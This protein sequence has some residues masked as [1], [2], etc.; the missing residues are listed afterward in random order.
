MKQKILFEQ[1]KNTALSHKILKER[2]HEVTA[3]DRMKADVIFD[4]IVKDMTSAKTTA[5]QQEVQN[6]G[7]AAQGQIESGKTK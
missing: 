4:F 5:N 1:A 3:M 7:E 2:G 6:T